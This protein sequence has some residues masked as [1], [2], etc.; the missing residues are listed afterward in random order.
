MAAFMHRY[1]QYSGQPVPPTSGRK[2]MLQTSPSFWIGSDATGWRSSWL[3]CTF[4]SPFSYD[5]VLTE[6]VIPTSIKQCTCEPSAPRKIACLAARQ[7]RTHLT[8][9]HND[10]VASRIRA[11]GVLCHSQCFDQA[12]LT[13]QR[14][15]LVNLRRPVD[16]K[17]LVLTL[18]VSSPDSYNLLCETLNYCTVKQQ[19][20]L[21]LSLCPPSVHTV[22]YVCHD[23]RFVWVWTRGENALN[24]SWSGLTQEIDIAV[25][26]NLARA[27]WSPWQRATKCNR[28]EQELGS[29]RTGQNW[30]RVASGG[31]KESPAEREARVPRSLF[32]E[33]TSSNCWIEVS[34]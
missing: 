28:A 8:S 27:I 21:V 16:L 18:V 17:F 6:N 15:Y 1:P 26:K 12:N 33:K 5:E 9:L 3:S 4:M 34:A 30:I 32:F 10:V 24:L 14:S 7:T 11:Y 13:L 31:E 29:A 2:P 22:Q 19:Q 23:C 25:K 20:H